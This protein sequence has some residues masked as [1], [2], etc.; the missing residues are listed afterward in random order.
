MASGLY[1][2]GRE[3]FLDGT[4]D[5]DG[6]QVDVYLVDLA[7][8]TYNVTHSLLSQISLGT[9]KSASLASKTCT[10]GVADAANTTLTTVT[11]D[12]SEA[13]ILVHNIDNRLI[14]FIDGFTVTPNSGDIT[15]QWDDT[16]NKIFKL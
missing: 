12:V 6:D 4:F 9:V 8:Y 7:D 10:D 14:A 13:L 1:N 2:K 16:G 3:G 15:I 11:G 5:W